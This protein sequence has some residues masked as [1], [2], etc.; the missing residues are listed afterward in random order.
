MEVEKKI[1][2]IFIIILLILAFGAID[3]NHS[4]NYSKYS[5]NKISLIN[6]EN[7]GFLK[8][9]NKS[10]IENNI[11]LIIDTGIIDKKDCYINFFI[12]DSKGNKI[13]ID[14]IQE[15]IISNRDGKVRDVGI[16]FS[17]T[18]REGIIH[19]PFEEIN[20]TMN[21]VAIIFKNITHKQGNRNITHKGKWKIS[22]DL[23][24]YRIPYDEQIYDGFSFNF[25]DMIIDA[26]EINVFP[27][28]T[29]IEF[30]IGQ[31]VS[32]FNNHELYLKD[33]N[34]KKYSSFSKHYSEIENRKSYICDF[35]SFYF[36][37][38]KKLYLCLEPELEYR[39]KNKIDKYKKE[40]EIKSI[41]IK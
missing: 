12:N 21:Y 13:D 35:E 30:E 19:F 14:E 34:G 6:A 5:Y 9:I 3:I 40:I 2:I 25:N 33:Q 23:N 22:L 10:D 36:T 29:V 4:K 38:P 17:H 1:L 16:N 31:D 20:G 28:S 37:K 11:R 27:L 32:F 7:N 26:R 39:T 24:K 8:E 15:I 41:G 18:T